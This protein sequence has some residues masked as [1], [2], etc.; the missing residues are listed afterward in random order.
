M[1]AYSS[2]YL[3]DKVSIKKF[4]CICVVI[5]IAGCQNTPAL[6]SPL[7]N[8]GGDVT[9]I[10]NRENALLNSLKTVRVYVDDTDVCAI[11][12]GDSCQVNTSSGKHILRVFPYGSTTFG[13]FSR[14]YEFISGKT[15]RFVISPNDTALLVNFVGPGSVVYSAAKWSTN[16]DGDS[17][18]FTMKILDE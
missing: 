14:H 5:L 9:L 12:N 13:T 6:V 10:F 1:Y 4:L 3:R 11:P 2:V 7:V 17:G 8:P 18:D 15:Y 16:G